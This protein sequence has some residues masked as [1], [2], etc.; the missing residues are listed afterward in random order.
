MTSIYD[1]NNFVRI[2]TKIVLLCSEIHAIYVKS[3]RCIEVGQLFNVLRICL[4]NRV[5]S[6]ICKFIFN[7]SIRVEPN[8]ISQIEILKFLT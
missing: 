6:I 4:N 7:N 5:L 1:R 3:E 8:E 2:F